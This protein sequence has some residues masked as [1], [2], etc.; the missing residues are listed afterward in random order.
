MFKHG[1]RVLQT[2]HSVNFPVFHTQNISLLLKILKWGR[3]EQNLQAGT[4]PLGQGSGLWPHSAAWDSGAWPVTGRLLG[5]YRSRKGQSFAWLHLPHAVSCFFLLL[6]FFPVR[7]LL[8]VVSSWRIQLPVYKKHPPTPP[9]LPTPLIPL[10]TPK[11]V[12]GVI[13]SLS[14]TAVVGEDREQCVGCMRGEATRW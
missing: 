2:L 14:L 8:T 12:W 11:A 6:P 9:P 13:Y 1:N 5:N 10:Q 4:F 3:A 7:K